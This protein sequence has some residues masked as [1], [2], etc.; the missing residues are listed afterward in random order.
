MECVILSDDKITFHWGRTGVC[1]TSNT[2]LKAEHGAN[3]IY[4]ARM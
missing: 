1:A 2:E 4:P 3:P